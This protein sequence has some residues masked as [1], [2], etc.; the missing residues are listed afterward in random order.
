MQK[1]SML[2]ITFLECINSIFRS[3]HCQ[4]AIIDCLLFRF[5]DEQI[6][7]LSIARYEVFLVLVLGRD[8]I[9]DVD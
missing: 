7:N 1:M 2:F 4:I 5:L 8:F 3:H 6:D 9:L